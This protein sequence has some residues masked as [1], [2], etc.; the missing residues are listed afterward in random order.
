[1]S[2]LCIVKA[3]CGGW[4]IQTGRRPPPTS[5]IPTRQ[6]AAPPYRDRNQL[7]H[8]NNE[9]RGRGTVPSLCWSRHAQHWN[10]I[11]SKPRGSP[12]ETKTKIKG[13]FFSSAGAVSSP[14]LRVSPTL[15]PPLSRAGSRKLPSTLNHEG[16]RQQSGSRTIKKKKKGL[17]VDSRAHPMK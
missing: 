2:E 15:L 10:Q 4:G 1:M 6:P 7:W 8:I 14:P 9:G 17:V 11:C 12:R 16:R 13:P 3:K 5:A